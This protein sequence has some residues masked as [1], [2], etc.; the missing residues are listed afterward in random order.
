MCHLNSHL[1]R[2]CNHSKSTAVTPCAHGYN[3]TTRRCNIGIQHGQILYEAFPNL[4][5][6][7]YRKVEARICDKHDERLRDIQNDLQQLRKQQVDLA[8]EWDVLADQSQV[9][10]P[11]MEDMVADVAQRIQRGE[12]NARWYRES[13]KKELKKFRDN[14]GVWGDG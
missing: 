2:E 4:C 12:E 9:A 13:R 1:Y 5:P 8:Q 3:E 10:G 11:V 6:T 14:Q 7:C